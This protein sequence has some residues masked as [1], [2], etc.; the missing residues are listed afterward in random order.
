L[1]LLGKSF[2]RWLDTWLRKRAILNFFGRTTGI[3]Q[4]FTSNAALRRRRPS[5]KDGGTLGRMF[6]SFSP[7]K[8]KKQKETEELS[9]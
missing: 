4:K 7:F 8:T 5:P 6:F 3:W 1:A 9:K 2:S